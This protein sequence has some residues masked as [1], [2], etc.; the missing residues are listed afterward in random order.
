MSPRRDRRRVPWHLVSTDGPL[1]YVENTLYWLGRR[2]YCDGRA[3]SPPKLAHARKSA[4]W[5][6]MPQGY[7]ITG[8]LV[9]NAE[10]EAAL[11]ARLPALMA[12]FRE[13]IESLGMEW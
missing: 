12:K 1:H 3:N 10:V 11:A 13:V 8:T 7:L 9:S 5:P 2:G 6:D 4:V